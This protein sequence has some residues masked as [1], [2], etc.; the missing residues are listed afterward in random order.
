MEQGVGGQAGASTARGAAIDTRCVDVLDGVRAVAVFGVVWF[1]FW[2]Q[3][4]ISP[5]FEMPFLRFVGLSSAVSLDFLPRAGYLFVDWLLLLSAFCL[6]LPHAR[7]VLAGEP[8]PAA[9]AFY[10]KRV[11]RIVPSYLLSVLLILFCV[12]IPAGTYA[13]LREC[14]RD[15][16]PTITFTQTF[17]P[18]VLLDTKL[19]GV[20]W[21]AAVEMQFYLLFP[22]L[23][24]WFRRAPLWTYLGMT[25]VSVLYLRISMRNVALDL[26]V[27]LNQLPGF[28]GVFANG[29]A[30][31]YFFVWFA[32]RFRRG[33]ALSALSLAGLLLGLWL[34]AGMMKQAASVSPV[35]PWQAEYRH[36]LSL[37]FALITLSAAL[38]FKA[39]RVL[40]SNALTRYLSAISYN[41]YIWHQWIAVK[42]K[43]WRIPYWSGDTPP[44]ITGDRAWQWNYALLIL[45]VSLL[46]ATAATYLVE[47]P[48][49]KRLLRPRPPGKRAALIEFVPVEAETAASAAE[50]EDDRKTEHGNGEETIDGM[51]HTCYPAGVCSRRIDFELR[52]GA[53]H[54]VVFTD[55]CDGNL[56]AL[57]KLAE[58][59]EAARVVE[60]LSGNTCRGKD[61]SCAD[62]LARAIRAAQ[63]E[64]FAARESAQQSAASQ[65]QGRVSPPETN[66]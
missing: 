27:L 60:L 50:T 61:T 5:Y 53:L 55:G 25:L 29:M 40:F 37:V 43:Q 28:F 45:G 12:E 63:E 66:L 52:G 51:K 18:G 58:G 62:Q 35:Q 14:V 4:W 33:T 39:V 64:E 42:F 9:R 7:A 16:L 47:R 38:T 54:N 36:R 21:T 23:A 32:G 13:S 59:M 24:R 10:R 31:S 57:C 30:L 22:L 56:K 17:F 11:A 8:V 20:L 15:L 19:N 2:Q 6:F 41:M 49:A 3:S 1:H 46:A 26:R 65:D 48:A 44:N 34:L